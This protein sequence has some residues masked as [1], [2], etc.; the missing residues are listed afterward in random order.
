MTN[1]IM[2]IY[3][4]KHEVS[5]LYAYRGNLQTMFF[6]SSEKIR[7]VDWLYR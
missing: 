1:G 5:P 7:L 3:C 4:Q 6:F 2:V